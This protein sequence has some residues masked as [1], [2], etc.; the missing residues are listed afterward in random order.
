MEGDASLLN[1]EEINHTSLSF[2]I[3]DICVG[4]DPYVFKRNDVWHLLLQEDFNP[5]PGAHEGIKGYTIRRA[6]NIEDLKQAE[7]TALLVSEQP[8]GL[9]QVW[10][11][12]IHFDSYMYVAMSDGDN[13]T[14]RMH[15]YHTDGDLIGPWHYLGPLQ[16]PEQDDRW[17]I[18]LTLAVIKIGEVDRM[19]AVWS[20]WDHVIEDNVPNLYEHIVPQNIYIAEFF[21]PTTIGPRHLLLRPEGEWCCSVASILEGPQTLTLEGEF[22]GILVTGNASWTEQYATSVLQYMGGDPLQ[23]TSWSLHA[24]LLFKGGHGIG[25]GMIVEDGDQLYYVGHR[26]TV[27]MHGWSDRMVF[28]TPLPKAVFLEYLK[29][30]TSET[31]VSEKNNNSYENIT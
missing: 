14:H 25:H 16:V 17:A 12:E 7:P 31:S 18:D 5:D 10:A 29:G 23:A 9:K 2:Q 11:A 8:P 27:R 30:G 21:T 26:K 20:G 13:H 22:K 6:S 28:Y 3:R 15:V 19:Y 1:I 4:A 24:D